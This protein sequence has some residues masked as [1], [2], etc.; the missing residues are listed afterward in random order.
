MPDCL[1]IHVQ[2]GGDSLLGDPVLKCLYHHEM[3]LDR[4]D[5][6]HLVVIGKRLIVGRD[7]AQDFLDPKLPEKSDSPASVRSAPEGWRVRI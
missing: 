2:R 1:D 4:L 7:Q 3:S 5:D 6:V